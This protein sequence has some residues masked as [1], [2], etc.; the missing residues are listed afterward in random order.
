M[1]KL[2]SIGAMNQLSNALEKAGYT[3]KDVTKLKQFNDLIGIKYLIHGKA[4]IVYPEN[5]ESKSQVSG[6]LVEGCAE[7]MDCKLASDDNVLRG[8]KK[9][10]QKRFSFKNA[11]KL[12]HNVIEGISSWTDY[13]PVRN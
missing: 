7:N 3:P 4:A 9:D 11:K 13:L 12:L 5:I 6:A 10:R 8:Q 1:S 2:F